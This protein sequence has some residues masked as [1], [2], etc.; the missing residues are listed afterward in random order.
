MTGRVFSKLLFSFLLVLGLGTAILYL[1]LRPIVRH[2][3]Y[4]EARQSLTGKA[5]LV[6]QAFNQTLGSSSSDIPAEPQA[7]ARFAEAQA[8]AAGVRVSVL[9]VH[10]QL[11]AD[12]GGE[13]LGYRMGW[14]PEV[15]TLQPA[16]QPAHRDASGWSAS[17]IRDGV[18]Y[19][20]VPGGVGG[21]RYILRLAYPLDSVRQTLSLL[22]RDLLLASLLGLC[23]ATLMAAY[24]AKRVAQRLHRIVS[25]ANRIAAGDLSARVKESKLDEISEVAGALDTTAARLEGSFK[26]LESSRRELAALL[27]S[28]Q[29]AVVGVSPQSGITWSNSA[30]QRISPCAVREGRPLVECVRDPDVLACAETAMRHRTQARGRATSFL[31]GR[32]FDVSAAPMPGDGAVIVLH[33]VTDIERAERMR[34]D[35]VANV[36]HE[37]RTPLTS[38]SGYVETV[39]E[40]E[41]DLSEQGREFLSVVIRNANRMNRLT[42]D[43]L[44]LADVEA[45]DYRV[46][47]ERIAADVLVEDAVES[48]GGLAMES[49]LVIE[50]ADSPRT[51]VLADADA[52][53]QVFANLIENAMKYGR[54]GGRVLVGARDVGASSSLRVA[55]AG[56]GNRSQEG[57]APGAQVEFFV[58]D[59]GQGIASEHLT[60]IFERFYRVDKARSR[61]SGGTGLGLAIA[62]HIVLAHGGTIRAESELGLGATF[63]FSLPVAPPSEQPVMSA[64]PESSVPAAAGPSAIV[65]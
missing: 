61:D 22:R 40:S 17:D 13:E 47:P 19:V 37:L 29:Q 41:A 46:R 51:L 55:A 60:R 63:V 26:A 5:R 53:T 62:R 56:A 6:A 20:T 54:A 65:S 9:D 4:D 14:A 35:F 38:I 43:L 12:S 15:Q 64:P 3:L 57:S 36:S 58:Q 48:L 8:L 23:V 49:G 32:V 59:F 11:L 16:L 31:P 28:M 50:I 45:G 24:L 25:F 18:L 42:K 21:T 1:S 39:L 30:M 34:R 10:G 44:A 27:D 7:L 52:L 2:S 33:D